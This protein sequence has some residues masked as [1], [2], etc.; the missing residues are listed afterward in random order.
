M[1]PI[2]TLTIFLS[3]TLLFFVQPMFA[4]MVLP[5][6]GGTPSVWN[7]CMVFFQ[8]ALLG[9]YLY[10][11]LST[12]WLGV[13]RQAVVHLLV[14]LAPLLFLPIAIG[15]GWDPPREEIPI[16][17]LMLVLTAVVGAPFFV[18]AATAPLLQRWFSATDHPRARDPYFLYAASNAGSMLALLGYPV[19]IE[20]LL[21]LP[22]QS[23]L[24]R[25]GYWILLAGLAG[26]TVLLWR[27]STD[28]T[29]HR[30]VEISESPGTK[31]PA[32][33]PASGASATNEVR[34]T[35]ERPVTAFRF[36]RWVLLAAIPSSLLLGVT[37]FITTD[38]VVVPLLWVIPLAIYLMTFMFVFA[39]RQLIPHALMA[40]ALPIAAI[41]L[42]ILLLSSATQPMPLIVSVHLIAFFILAMVNH[43]ELARDR[44]H[45]SSLTT[46][47]L[48]M[49]LGGLLGGAF[50]GVLAPI[51][52]PGVVEYPLAIVLACLLSPGYLP[53]R[54]TEDESPAG[55]RWKVHDALWALGL[56]AVALAIVWLGTFEALETAGPA[57]IAILAG[58]PALAC[59]LL[60]QRPVRFGLC[61]GAV[62]LATTLETTHLGEL[63]ERDRTFFGVHRV[64]LQRYTTPD[65]Q[66]RATHDLHHGTTLH[67]Q[68]WVDPE[69]RVP[70]RPREPLTYYHPDGPIGHV[71]RSRNEDRTFR[72]IGLVGLGVGAL[73]AYAE[74]EQR[75]HFFEIDPTV[76]RIAEDTRY[77][78]YLSEARER[79]AMI[80]TT[81]GDARLT[82]AQIDAGTFDLLVIDAFSSDSIPVHL[83]TLEAIE[84]YLRTVADDGLIAL[85]ISN[86]Y[87]DLEPVLAA[88]AE[89]LNLAA[90]VNRDTSITPEE[91]DRT[92]RQVSRWVVLARDDEDVQELRRG[93]RGSNWQP[94]RL[95]DDRVLWTDDYSNF[96]RILMW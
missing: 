12:R 23:E 92:G 44:P 70:I 13:R 2:Y 52:F 36:W 77:F 8:A 68:Q 94:L 31:A 45:A 71:F 35:R 43:G 33:G 81:L 60:S 19:V 9:G 50:N 24:W 74:P 96:L 21:P 87:L 76:R 75:M 32:A 46:F 16:A 65:G 69:S 26:C 42:M 6:L 38:L 18:V 15:A 47:Y 34:L 62:M 10:A 1:I 7:T 78:T 80:E 27:R 5:L 55:P 59:Y 51:I 54:R 14:M 29:V 82:L 4:K 3:A 11:H 61:V 95:V 28:R 63:L 89:E 88:I 53:L 30:S 58:V 66:R 41:T 86:R 25:F 49:G 39:Q 67:G 85:H 20:P 56:G 73:A 64:S 90:Y 57:R 84:S 79:G 91:T 83:V 37:T 48:A 22:A 72:N 93:V 17:W 40:R